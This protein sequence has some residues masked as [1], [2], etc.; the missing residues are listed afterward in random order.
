MT[1][2]LHLDKSFDIMTQID[3]KNTMAHKLTK[4]LEELGISKKGAEVY[5]T[6]LRLGN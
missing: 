4:Y 3:N 2:T 6:L 1:N 5:L